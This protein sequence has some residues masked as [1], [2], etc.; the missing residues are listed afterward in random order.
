MLEKMAAIT[1]AIREENMELSAYIEQ[2]V[3]LRADG[4]VL[5][6]GLEK[7]HLFERQIMAPEA[8]AAYEKAIKQ[9]WGEKAQLLIQ[10]NCAEALPDRTLAAERARARR[11]AHAAAIEEVKNHP[12]VQEAVQ[13]FSAQIINVTLPEQ[14]R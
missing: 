7:G 12:R 13:I 11:R 6:L 2:A 3:P 10:Q 5:E 4:T 14:A 8:I 9:V 1:D